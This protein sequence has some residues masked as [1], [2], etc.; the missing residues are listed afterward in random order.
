MEGHAT[1]DS[2]RRIRVRLAALL[3]ACL[4]AVGVEIAV[5]SRLI[6]ELYIPRPSSVLL[7]ISQMSQETATYGHLGTTLL[8]LVIGLAA[9]LVVGFV[10]GVCA[11]ISKSFDVLLLDVCSLVMSIPVI[12]IA[13]LL[14]LWM[15]IGIS[16]KI[17]LALFAAVAPIAL[18]T[19]AG[20]LSVD[21]GVVDAAKSLGLN[22]VKRWGLVQ[23]PVASLEIIS[24]L[25]IGTSRAFVGVL[26][27]EMIAST[28]GV[29]WLIIHASGTFRS[30]RLFVALFFVCVISLLFS[31]VL[32]MAEARVSAWRST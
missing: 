19:R 16:A 7:Q 2:G 31:L 20:L 25:R 27:A 32:N 17:V 4:L 29:G 13:P 14:T 15:G 28:M 10:A 9:S 3:T 24:G 23:F 30:D 18:S 8:E 26:A 5:S 21:K 11:T 22:A 1:N 12:A 6:P